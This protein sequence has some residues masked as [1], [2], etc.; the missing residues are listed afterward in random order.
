MP[1]GRVLSSDRLETRPYHRD[2][3]STKE[4]SEQLRTAP[5][6]GHHDTPVCFQKTVPDCLFFGSEQQ[7]V[8]GCGDNAGAQSVCHTATVFCVGLAG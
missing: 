4:F 8:R 6:A 3:G 7:A 5:A 1:G 2:P